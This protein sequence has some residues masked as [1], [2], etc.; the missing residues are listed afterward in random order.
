LR[1]DIG[2]R[3]DLAPQRPDIVAKLRPLVAA[4]EKDVDGEGGLK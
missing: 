3:N 2:E 4:W 1:A